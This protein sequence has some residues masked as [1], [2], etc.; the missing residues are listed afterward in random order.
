[1][2]KMVKMA[3]V[4]DDDKIHVHLLK[5]VIEIK[6]LAEELMVFENGREALNHLKKI[7]TNPKKQQILPEII[8]LDLNMPVMNGW[9]FLQEFTK[10]KNKLEQKISLYVMSSSI[11]A[12]ELERAQSLN[13]IKDYLIKPL[14]LKKF[15]KIFGN[16]TAA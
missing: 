13:L 10:L 8:F 14:E 5:K 9:E 4:I 12:Q 11:D 1:M 2:R 15:E 3:Y 16:D 7:L 6:A